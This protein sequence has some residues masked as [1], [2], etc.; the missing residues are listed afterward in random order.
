MFHRCTL[1]FF[2]WTVNTQLILFAE[3][4]STFLKAKC[5][6]TSTN[7]LYDSG[8]IRW[9]SVKGRQ[10]WHFK[11]AFAS[12]CK[13]DGNFNWFAFKSY[14]TDHY[15]VLHITRQLCYYDCQEQRQ[16]DTESEFPLKSLCKTVGETCLG[17]FVSYMG[18]LSECMINDAL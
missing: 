6:T 2:L 10:R 3:G 9:W 4:F 12:W 18:H 5:I 8:G 11:T 7:Q 14:W 17:F 13:F 15:V 16:C 1:D